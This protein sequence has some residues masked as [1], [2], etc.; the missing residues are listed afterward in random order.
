M[1]VKNWLRPIRITGLGLLAFSWAAAGSPLAAESKWPKRVLITNDDGIDSPATIELAK[2]FSAVAETYLVAPMHDRSGSSNFVSA[3]TRK[4]FHVQP[5]D[6]A[7][8]VKAWAVS[9]YPGDC[10][11]FALGG[12]MRESPPDLVISGV[13]TGPNLGEVWFFSGTIG[14]ARTAA[15]FGIPALAVSGVDLEDSRGVAAVAEWVVRLAR[16]EMVRDLRTGQ[17]LTVSIPVISPSKI[18]GIEIVERASG[19]LEL[20]AERLPNDQESSEFQEWSFHL[21]WGKGFPA[22]NS[23]VAAAQRKSI[24]I[25]PMQV[26]EEDPEMRKWLKENRD[27]IPKWSRSGSLN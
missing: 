9:G 25:V 13:N 16:S 10:I 18:K 26:N 27:L 17:Y 20:L 1:R 15:A 21:E 11:L 5:R 8:G 23:D 4:S 3:V 7:P 14:A 24:A 19:F 12:P 22:M 6:V 2:K